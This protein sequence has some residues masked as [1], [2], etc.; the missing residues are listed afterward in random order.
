MIAILDFGGQYTHLIGRRFRDMRIAVAIFPHDVPASE[1]SGATGI[2]FSGGPSSVNA[3]GAPIPDPKI[4]SLGIPILGLCYG[5]Q[6]LAKYFGGKVKRVEGAKEYGE[7]EI[8]VVKKEGVLK[9]VG[10]K[11]TVWYSHGDSVLD[12]PSGFEVLAKSGETVAAMRKGGVYGLQFHP[13]VHHT[14]CGGKVLENFAFKVCGEEKQKDTFSV[15]DMVLE[16]K[17]RV[18]K[19]NVVIGVSGGVDSS[20]AAFLLRKAIGKNLYPIF[21]DNGFLRKGEV[22]EVR[23]RFKG[24]DNFVVVDASRKFLDAVKGIDEPELKRKKIGH[25]FVEVFEDAAKGVPNVGFLAQGTIFSDRVESAATSKAASKIK[26]HH[27]LTLPEKMRW[28]VLEP[29]AELYKDETRALG[30]TL[31]LPDEVVKRHPFPGPGLAINVVGEVTPDKLRMAREADYIFI[32]ELRKAGWYDKMFEAFAAVLPCRTVGVKG[33]ERSYEFPIVLRAV[34]SKDVM[35]ADWVRLPHDLLQKVASRI[36]SEVPG[37]NRVFYDIS[38][39]PPSTIR[40]E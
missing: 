17:A 30:K 38:Q 20:V 25:M 5:H 22:E 39:K 6:Y 2:I 10:S 34:E 4:F 16:A 33:D 24:F 32:E 1:L 12:V 3:E 21:V 14:P 18:G 40:Y 7:K 8:S 27:N 29:L 19:K 36:L 15:E 26:S 23:A 28:Q 11:E 13:E 35:T 31:G 37:V 9:G